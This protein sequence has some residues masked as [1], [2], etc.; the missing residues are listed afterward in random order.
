MDSQPLPPNVAPPARLDIAHEHDWEQIRAATTETYDGVVMREFPAPVASSR[1]PSVNLVHCTPEGLPEHVFRNLAPEHG[2]LAPRGW[3]AAYGAYLND[4]GTYRSVG[5]EKVRESRGR[6][7]GD[8]ARG[9][10][11]AH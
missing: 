10:W 5:D 1:C 7:G 8:D 6:G 4:D 2:I 3:I 11:R 9:F